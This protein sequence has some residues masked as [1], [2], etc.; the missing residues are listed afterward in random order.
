M[1]VCLCG[2][3]LFVELPI[4]IFLW[5]FPKARWLLVRHGFCSGSA[6]H[7][8]GDLNKS[9]PVSEPQLPLPK[10]K[11]ITIS[12]AETTSVLS[13]PSLPFL[14]PTCSWAP[15]HV[16]QKLHFPSF[17]AA[18]GS[19]MAN[20]GQGDVSI[21]VLCN[22]LEGPCKRAVSLSLFLLPIIWNAVVMQKLKQSCWAMRRKPCAEHDGAS[23]EKEL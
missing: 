23:G 15:G 11:I 3:V 5:R 12:V 1:K 10:S 22:G 4:C 16:E 20:S 19:H 17:P 7:C 2:F 13:P 6:S 21:N 8:P 18:R 14:S 9:M